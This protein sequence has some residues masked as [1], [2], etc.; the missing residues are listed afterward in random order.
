MNGIQI[1]QKPSCCE[2]WGRLRGGSPAYQQKQNRRIVH[3]CNYK[4]KK[5]SNFYS[6]KGVS[7]AVTKFAHDSMP[8][9]FLKDVVEL[10]A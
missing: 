1:F 5:N 4:A 6:I 2:I 8:A 7:L 3:F 9:K 10:A